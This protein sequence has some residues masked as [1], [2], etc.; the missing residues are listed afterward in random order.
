VPRAWCLIR[1]APHYRSEAFRAGL[2]RAGYDVRAGEPS[3]FGPGDVLTVWNRYGH[4]DQ[5]ARQFE[6]RGAR[7][8]V[9]ENGYLGADTDGRQRYALALGQHNGGGIWPRDDGSRWRALNIGIKPWR[10]DGA[11][12]L[13]CAQRGIGP[14]RYAQP[15]IWPQ[16]VERRLKALTARPVRVRLHPG[17]WQKEPPRIPLT[18]DLRGCWCVVTWASGAGIHALLVGIPVIYEGPWWILAGAA[19][20]DIAVVDDPPLPARESAFERLAC[21]Q[22]TVEEIESGEPFRRLLNA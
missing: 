3:N 9:A 6:A 5:Y 1:E 2:A 21:A 11:H 10:K 15:Q 8:I 7:V 22:W 19:S 16:D 17:N 4:F 18:E 13:V 20:R 14:D 12:V